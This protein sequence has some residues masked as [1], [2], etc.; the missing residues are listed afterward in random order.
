MQHAS[1]W[2]G[3]AASW[4]DLTTYLPGHWTNTVAQDIWSDGAT[5]YIAGHGTNL[6]TGRG[7]AI[8]WSH[9]NSVPEP[10]GR[11]LA[12]L[13]LFFLVAFLRRGSPPRHR[14]EAS[15]P[16]LGW[17]RRRRC[18][19]AAKFAGF[20]IL[21]V[22]SAPASAQWTAW[23][24]NPYS[25][26]QAS[27]SVVRGGAGSQV[28]EQAFIIQDPANE[29]HAVLVSGGSPP[30]GG[31]SVFDLNPAGA[32][33]SDAIGTTGTQQVGQATFGSATHAGL[34]SGTAASWIDLN[35]I[36]AASSA[37]NGF[38]SVQQVGHARFGNATHAGLWS[39]TAA[40]WIDLNP[41]GAAGSDALGTNG[42]H[43]VGYA[44]LSNKNHAGLWSGAAASWVDLN[45]VGATESSAK[46]VTGTQE[47]GAAKFGSNDHA[48]MWTGTAA[49]WVDLNP[50]GATTSQVNG[51][52]GTQQVGQATFGSG[53]HASL[54]SGSAGTWVD[55]NP[56][57]ATTSVAYAMLGTTQVG[58]ATLNDGTTRAGVWHGTAASWEPLPYDYYPEEGGGWYPWAH[59]E[60]SSVWT[61]GNYL[62]AAGY[63]TRVH[64][65]STLQDPNAFLW[66]LPISSGLPG[67]FNGDNVV[68]AR[69]YVV[70]R[71]G[72]GTTYS[73]A[74]YSVWRS[75]FGQT[76]GSGAAGYP[77]GASAELLPAAVPEP[78]SAALLLLACVGLSAF[79][80]RRPAPL[81]RRFTC[82]ESLQAASTTPQQYLAG[83]F[84]FL[85]CKGQKQ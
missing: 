7:E 47:I 52:F 8:L 65:V 45:P 33:G 49:S 51:I 20:I 36:G 24:F 26:E 58:Y 85:V 16:T 31:Y 23:N 77:L 3:T 38:T 81:E 57:G 32:T 75:H 76:A 1:L 64:Y 73:Q 10:G 82:Q 9:T 60:S 21:T 74:D 63:V 15:S 53:A 14:K 79:W 62:Y 29:Y 4:V 56:A 6:D 72:L 44:T 40:S 37:P 50:A 42:A 13:G 66:F 27:R 43:Q 55:L 39:G 83:R 69:D 19:V 54:W 35:P 48:G 78:G 68:D 22:A 18:P 71:K 41:A 80:R 17:A 2:S 70:W 25:Y 12:G 61:N 5:T 67:D 59:A 34:W 28:V 84:I 46:F 30:N 11:L